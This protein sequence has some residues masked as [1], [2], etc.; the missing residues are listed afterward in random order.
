MKLSALGRFRYTGL[1]F[2]LVSKNSAPNLLYCFSDIFVL[3]VQ[4]KVIIQSTSD[5]FLLREN[6]S[7]PT[8][9]VSFIDMTAHTWCRI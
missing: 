6:H 7:A 8:R 9:P 4:W 2:S 1:A 3:I 5:T